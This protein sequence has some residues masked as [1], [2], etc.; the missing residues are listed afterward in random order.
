MAYRP[1]APEGNDDASLSDWLEGSMVILGL[2]E[3]SRSAITRMLANEPFDEEFSSDDSI[4]D[5]ELEE[6]VREDSRVDTLLTA[7]E[8]RASIGGDLYPFRVDGDLILFSGHQAGCIYLF[9]LWVCI[10]GTPFRRRSEYD[11]PERLFDVVA[12]QALRC[13]LGEPAEAMLFSRKHA[14]DESDSPLVRPMSFPKAILR[15]REL[16]GTRGHRLPPDDP[17]LAEEEGLP[18]RT[19]QDGGVDVIAWR[20]FRDDVA[21]F[22]VVLAQCSIQ[23]YWRGKTRDIATDLWNAW[24][25]FPTPF[26]RVLVI[27]WPASHDPNW[28]DRNREAGL[29]IDRMRTC[30]LLD[31]CGADPALL[32]TQELEVWLAEQIDGY[33]ASEAAA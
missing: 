28:F 33:S 20:R 9:L 6:L 18:A 23:T 24:V 2:E 8:R 22:P 3:A 30:E 19:Y 1:F 32:C 26:Q 21:A 4:D 29:I 11:F 15:V 13:L 7:V 25:L 17:D 31:R 5:A 12:A 16:M 10:P 27:P 14:D